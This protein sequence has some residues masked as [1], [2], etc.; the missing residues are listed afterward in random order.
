MYAIVK[1]SLGSLDYAFDVLEVHESENFEVLFS[2]FEKQKKR[3][4]DSIDL[5]EWDI[6]FEEEEHI[7]LQTKDGEDSLIL[8][9]KKIN[10]DA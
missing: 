4:L 2:S 6:A 1:Y 8:E 5:N 10:P 7:I 9:I 3:L